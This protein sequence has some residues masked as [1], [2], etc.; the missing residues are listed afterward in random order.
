MIE[1]RPV[2]GSLHGHLRTVEQLYELTARLGRCQALSEVCEA[3]VDA[4]IEVAG[5][6]RASVLVFDEHGV[7]RFKAWRGLSSEYRAAVDG[8]S[9]WTADVDDPTPIVVEDVVTDT[10][11]GSLR[12]LILSEGIQ[13]LGFIPV[14]YRGRLLGKFMLYHDRPHQFSAGELALAA[15]IADHVGFAVARAQADAAIEAALHRERTARSEAD[16]AR[17]EAE[18]ESAAKDEFLA[19]LAHELRNP[20]GAV[21]SALAVM[22]AGEPKDPGYERSLSAI[23]RQ[24]QHLARLLDDLLDVARITRGEIRL[25]AAPLDMR[26]VLQLGIENQRHRLEAKRQHLSLSL[27]GQPVVVMGDSVR[28]QQVFGNILH[29]A[30]KYTPVGGAISVELEAGSGRAIAQIRDSGTGIAPDRLQ[31]IFE[32]FN[33][34][35]PT[36]ARTEGGLGIG[37]TVAKRLMKLHDGDIRAMSDGLGRGSLFI[38]ELPLNARAPLQHSTPAPALSGKTKRILVIEDNEDGREM[39]VAALRMFGHDVSAAATGGEGVEKA[40]HLSPDVV[41]ID[42]GLPDI[43]GY[44]VA[45]ELREKLAPGT[46]L[47][48]LTGYG[49]LA[50]RAKS[51]KA[52]FDAHLLKPVEPERLMSALESLA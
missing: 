36:L 28:L 3:A 38:L 45:R 49:G 29:N 11:V 37:L 52:G 5:V 12:P 13:A 34:A 51:E 22:Q 40:V 48:A 43:Q 16:A 41:L 6:Q 25:D 47:V 46:R 18:R 7:M 26:S 23:R 19:M 44:D 10:G 39:L 32:L 27:P 21:V 15:T 24:T 31:W 9:P 8:H 2:E 50:D 33:Q 4:I 17:A 1:N 20:L 14:V 30:T 35:D 42:I